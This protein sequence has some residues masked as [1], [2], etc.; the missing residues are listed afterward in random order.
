MMIYLTTKR[1]HFD[2][3]LYIYQ[4]DNQI[5]PKETFKTFSTKNEWIK[6][7]TTAKMQ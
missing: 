3:Q 4:T 6:L 5:K 1:G 2:Q 7:A